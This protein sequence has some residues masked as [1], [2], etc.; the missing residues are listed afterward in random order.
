MPDDQFPNWH[1]IERNIYKYIYARDKADRLTRYFSELIRHIK[2]HSDQR[3]E[4]NSLKLLLANKIQV[5]E[6]IAIE[7]AKLGL[8]PQEVVTR[9]WPG[10]PRHGEYALSKDPLAGV[11]RSHLKEKNLPITDEIAPDHLY[12]L[13]EAAQLLDRTVKTLY[14]YNAIKDMD[15][16]KAPV[17]PFQ[18]DIQ[19]RRVYY[20]GH[21]LI[22]FLEGQKKKAIE[23]VETIL[24]FQ[25]KNPSTKPDKALQ[26]PPS[27]K[28]MTTKQIKEYR[29]QKRGF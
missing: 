17:I 20:R 10:R 26:L 5:W 21:D 15:G 13:Q 25:S 11:D 22:N 2:K 4:L 3:E 23:T 19:G 24:A 8:P 12:T 1:E 9:L 14:D 16:R 6:N 7:E 18:K 28:R 27:R 29:K